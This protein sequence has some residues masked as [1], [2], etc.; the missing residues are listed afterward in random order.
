MWHDW[1]TGQVHT[2]LW[3]GNLMERAHFEDPGVD[4]G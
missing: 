4:G 1:E 2:G 3:W